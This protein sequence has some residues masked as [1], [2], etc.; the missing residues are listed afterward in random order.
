M[1]IVLPDEL[2][3]L[4]DMQP[5]DR[6]VFNYLAERTDLLTGVIGKA[7]K[8]SYGGMALD[9][10]EREQARR[11]KASLIKLTSKQVE[12]SVARLVSVGLLA[13]HS[14]SGENC[15]LVLSRVFL[16]P[17]L[18]LGYSVKNPDGRQLGDFLVGLKRIFNSNINEL[19]GNLGL[20]WEGKSVS[21][22]TTLNTQYQYK[23]IDK[24]SM[25]VD[26][27]PSQD[28]FDALI[29]RAGFKADLV[30][31]EWI[32]EFVA[33]WFARPGRQYSQAEWTSRLSMKCVDFLRDP[34]LFGRYRGVESRSP[35]QSRPLSRSDVGNLPDFARPPKDDDALVSWMK[36]YG[37]GEPPI[38]LS[39]REA[40]AW[41]ARK[42][43]VKLSEY[44]RLS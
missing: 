6:D 31:D 4:R 13:R 39:Y 17:F 3:I 35:A 36:R 19:Q 2:E 32:N 21:D 8:V 28:V 14:K 29:A 15:Q 24:F 42:I 7:V 22:G 11:A 27:Q 40:R 20:S 34:T 12:N 9:L 18:G 10:S 38:G 44:R 1:L 26:W 16:V 5:L 33:Y 41:L 25:S 30:K 37:Y 43:D 23:G